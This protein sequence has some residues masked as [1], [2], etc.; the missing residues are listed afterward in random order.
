MCFRMKNRL[1]LW[2]TTGTFLAANITLVSSL[3]SMGLLFSC[4]AGAMST[5]L[6]ILCLMPF[7]Y[8]HRPGTDAGKGR[9]RMVSSTVLF[10]EFM[11][12]HCV[13]GLS[14]LFLASLMATFIPG[15]PVVWILACV[16]VP[17]LLLKDRYPR[18]GLGRRLFHLT[19][20]QG[21]AQEQNA[22]S[23]SSSIVRNAIPLSFVIL[24]VLL[25]APD[26]ISGDITIGYTYLW[27]I[28]FWLMS[29]F[30]RC[31]YHASIVDM[32]TGTRLVRKEGV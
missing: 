8:L 32:I 1:L 2:V 17:F 13:Y 15:S 20:V 31:R 25:S 4:L 21:E 16:S 9:I 30:C 14:G 10:W 18:L 29:M 26:S 6:Q 24:T 27:F 11:I 12:D 5:S 22:C 3:S 19:C 7:A 23:V 28:V